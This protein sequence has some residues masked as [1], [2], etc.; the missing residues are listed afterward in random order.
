MM[1]NLYDILRGIEIIEFSGNSEIS[2]SSVEF[3]SRK[4]LDNSLFVATKGTQVDG[5]SFISDAIKLGAKAI[6]CEELPKKIDTEICYVVVKDSRSTLGII[7]SNWYNKPSYSLKLIGVTGTNGKTTVAS[8]LHQ[9]FMN[10]GYVAGLISTVEN[11]IGHNSL[12]STHTTPD[13][14]MINHL[15]AEMVESGC[16]FCFMEVSSHALDQGRTASLDFDGAVFTNLTHDHMDYHENFSQYLKAKKRLFDGLKQEA[17]ALSNGD[18]KNGSVI[19]QNCKAKKRTYSLKSI[20]DFT[21][22]IIENQISGLNLKIDGEGV[23]FRLVGQFNAYNLLAI[24]ATAIL[25]KQDKNEVLSKLSELSP[26]NGRFEH[27]SDREGITFVVDYAHSPDALLNVLQTIKSL[28]NQ[29]NRVLCVV[30]A[31]GNR[32]KSKRPEMAKIAVD[33]SH[34]VILTSDNPRFEDPES[35]LSDMKAGLSKLEKLKVLSISNRAE[36]IKTAYHLAQS[37]DIILVAGK[38]HETYQEIKGKK[39]H[40]DDKEL[41]INLINQ[42]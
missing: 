27:F 18:D 28:K 32:D 41:I 3:D 8:L 5:H 30:G 20:G 25:L 42:E 19:L 21:A 29:E 9:L 40:F 14:K 12:A 4:V 34:H 1:K 13:A 7:S 15:L 10:M 17:F 38:G 35:I 39:H 24:Y 37:G 16:E 36:A 11:K 2:V 31:G 23:W 33:Y 22:Q 6:V 26:V